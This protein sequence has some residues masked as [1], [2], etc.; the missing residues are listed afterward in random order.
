MNSALFSLKEVDIEKM[1]IGVCMNILC[2]NIFKAVNIPFC[3][4]IKFISKA[5]FQKE[6]QI[7]FPIKILMDPV[8][9]II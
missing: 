9:N 8:E 3:M 6:F 5:I 4:N 7:I 1:Q 2:R